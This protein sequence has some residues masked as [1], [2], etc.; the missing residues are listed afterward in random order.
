MTLDEACLLALSA[1]ELDGAVEVVVAHLAATAGRTGE[2]PVVAAP[3]ADRLH[4]LPV[5]EGRHHRPQLSALVQLLHLLGVA[6]QL[7]VDEDQGEGQ[8]RVAVLQSG[9]D[10]SPELS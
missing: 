5:L 4:G 7:P 8:V 6:Q 10:L 9:G 1:P 3:G 2:H